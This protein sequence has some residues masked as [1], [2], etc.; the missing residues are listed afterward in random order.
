MTTPNTAIAPFT[1]AQLGTQSL[2]GWSGANPATGRETAFLLTYS[3]GDGSD[4]PEAGERA[5]R[6]ALER[7]GLRIGGETLD[8]S[9][10]PNL[11]VKL[12]VQAGQAVLTLPHFNAQYPVPAEWLAVAQSEGQ[13]HGMFATRPWPAAVPGQPVSEELLSSFVGDSEVI[14]SSAHCLMPVRSLG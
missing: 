13:V 1:P 5:M 11:P 3:L 2:I 14:G 8:A 9:D 12:L 10:L 6:T 4:G 7:S